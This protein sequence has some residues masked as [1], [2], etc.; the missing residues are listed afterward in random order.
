MASIAEEIDSKKTEFSDSRFPPY[1]IAFIKEAVT[2][3]AYDY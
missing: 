1:C 2:K 3:Q